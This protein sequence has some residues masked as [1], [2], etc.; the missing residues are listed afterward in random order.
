MI[1]DSKIRLS[2]RGQATLPHLRGNKSKRFLIHLSGQ[3]EGLAPAHLLKKFRLNSMCFFYIR[4]LFILVILFL[5][6]STL[7]AQT[8]QPAQQQGM[9]GASTGEA[10]VYTTRRTI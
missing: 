9:G 6:H 7:F 5:A 2:G 1:V 3:E 8:G 4:A 10:K